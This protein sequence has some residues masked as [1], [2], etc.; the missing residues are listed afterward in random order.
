MIIIIL[1]QKKE[2][3]LEF[4]TFVST[5]DTKGDVRAVTLLHVRVLPSNSTSH[6]ALGQILSPE[7]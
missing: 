4:M 1:Y 6:S 2:M 3:R 7:R 5:T